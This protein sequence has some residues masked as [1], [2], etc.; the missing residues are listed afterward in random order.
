M[1]RIRFLI[2]AAAILMVLAAPCVIFF[3]RPPVLIVTDTP[4]VL[5][6][7]KSRLR[8]QQISASLA[9]F[10][11]V[12]PVMIA[13]GAG[14]DVV[15][16]A[17]MELAAQPFCVLFARDQAAA[18]LYF[19]EQFPETPAV[20]LSGLVAVPE[21]PSPDGFLCVY[22]TDQLTDL[23]RAGLF[24]GILGNAPPKPVEK[25][26]KQDESAAVPPNPA[27]KTYV[28]WQDRYVQAAGKDSFSRGIKEQDP[29]S[30]II[31]ANTGAEIP[32]MKG[33][34]SLVLTG[35]GAEYLEKNPRV[36]LIL[37]SWLDPAFTTRE[38]VVL[39]D[40]SAWA[41]AV[42]AVRMAAQKQA[43][44]KIPSQPLIFPERIADNNVF[45]M[46]QKSAKK[47]P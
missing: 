39:F 3:I 47:M 40:D 28:L 1:K 11:R 30:V 5:L 29:K 36:P 22:G 21:I 15:N 41:V 9:L 12:K 43:E 37:F 20:V 2:I 25:T 35:A 31:F 16:L 13:D 44:G 27:P 23:Y 19:H 6:Y 42:P 8:R 45:R 10:R 33:I 24:A 4:F 18:A 46:L 17:I 34:S 14:S 7:G 38:I 26:K 32:D